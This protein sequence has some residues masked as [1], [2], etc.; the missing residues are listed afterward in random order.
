MSVHINFEILVCQY[1]I[2][3][4]KEGAFIK[5]GTFN[6]INMVN[7]ESQLFLYFFSTRKKTL[8]CEI[9]ISLFLINRVVF[10]LDY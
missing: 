5:T 8:D 7:T 3:P 2:I 9:S 1:K 6:R 4:G 10:I